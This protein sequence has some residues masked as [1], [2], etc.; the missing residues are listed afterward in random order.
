M[1]ILERLF[2]TYEAESVIEYTLAN[3]SGMTVSC[4]N[5]GCVISKIV[6]PDR[7][8]NF[9]NVVLGFEDFND[10][11][12]WSPYFGAVVGRVAGR[13]NGAKF[14]L[15]GKEYR[16][17]A[18]EAPNHLHGGNKG[19]SSVIWRT[20]K[21]VT[22]DAVGVKFFYVSPDGEEGY[23]GNLTTSVTYL[24]TNEN[25]LCVTFEGRT[26]QKTLL[27]MTNHS[28]FNLSG[29]L[30][31][32]CLEH[33]L[34]LESDRFLELGPDLIPTGKMMDASGTPFDFYQERSLRDGKNSTHPQNVLAGNG[35]DHPLVFAKKGENTIVLRDKESG[36]GLAVTTNQPC[37][38]LYTS[39]Q[40]MGPFSISG[41]PAR[42]YLG[43]CL[44]TQGL[45]DA[46]HHPEFP[47]VILN[48]EEL[49]YSTTTYQ[50]FIEK[51]GE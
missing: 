31:R 27:N 50:F 16:L 9:E 13:I 6:A 48:P 43:V 19:F 14:T 49:Y 17:A 36:R 18:N 8:G 25:E 41:V 5:Y 20:E 32:D 51:L 3:D 30:K 26:D 21:L 1:K 34:Q 2:G 10:Y 37:V 45:P 33:K 24:L 15:D 39:N 28:Y 40:L 29:D 22:N 42:N 12:Q 46:I 11:L 47:T 38:V 35:Y 44:E 23:P 4:L 7:D